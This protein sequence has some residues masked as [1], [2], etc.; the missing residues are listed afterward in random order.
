MGQPTTLQLSLLNQIQLRDL[1]DSLAEEY[2]DV[3]K[4]RLR[5]KGV[6]GVLEEIDIR[7]KSSAGF[8][9]VDTG[10]VAVVESREFQNAPGLKKEAKATRK[11]IMLNNG[12]RSE[13]A[14]PASGSQRLVQ[15]GPFTEIRNGKKITYIKHGDVRLEYQGERIT[16]IVGADGVEIPPGK[17]GD[18]KV[19]PNEHHA[20][21][22]I[23]Q[24]AERNN[25]RILALSP[26]RG[27]CPHCALRMQQYFIQQNINLDDA[28]P[29]SRQ[30]RTLWRSFLKDLRAAQRTATSIDYTLKNP[31]IDI[32]TLRTQF[33]SEMSKFRIPDRR[34][35]KVS[36][37]LKVA[38]PAMLA[39]DAA[40][41]YAKAAEELDKGN[42]E[43]AAK[44]LA[45]FGGRAAG[46]FVGAEACGLAFAGFG[47]V[48]P[49]L[50]T[51]VGALAGIL[52]GGA[53]GAYL[54]EKGAHELCEQIIAW[55][56][57]GPAPERPLPPSALSP[58][59]SHRLEVQKLQ[60]AMLSMGY[61]APETSIIGQLLD[62]PR[63]EGAL[64]QNA[65]QQIG[66][67]LVPLD[68]ATEVDSW[69]TQYPSSDQLDEGVSAEAIG[70]GAVPATS[71]AVPDGLKPEAEA[72]QPQPENSRP[73]SN[74]LAQP[75]PRP[76][77]QTETDQLDGANHED[78]LEATK[79]VHAEL[80]MPAK[81]V[82]D[83]PSTGDEPSIHREGGPVLLDDMLERVDNLQR[84]LA[85]YDNL[86]TGSAATGSREQFEADLTELRAIQEQ[87]VLSGSMPDTL[88][89]QARLNEVR[90]RYEQIDSDARWAE[91]R[92]SESLRR[93]QEDDR[94]RAEQADPEDS[95]RA[96]QTIE[97][98][99][100]RRSEDQ[101][102]QEVEERERR[103]RENERR[104]E[105]V[106]VE[107]RRRREQNEEDLDRENRNERDKEWQAEKARQLD[108]ARQRAYEERIADDLQRR[109]EVEARDH[110]ANIDADERRREELQQQSEADVRKLAD[111]QR[112]RANEAAR[113]LADEQRIQGEI[114]AQRRDD[115][116]RRARDLREAEIRTE[117]KQLA[118]REQLRRADDL[119]R[120]EQNR[121]REKQSPRDDQTMPFTQSPPQ[122][123][124]N[125]H[126]ATD[127]RLTDQED[128]RRAEDDRQIQEQRRADQ[129][130]A[131]EEHRVAEENRKQEQ[132]DGARP[133]APDRDSNR[134]TDGVADSQSSHIRQD[135]LSDEK[136]SRAAEQD[137]V[138]QRRVEEERARQQQEE[139]Q[140][141]RAEE[142]Q[143][144]QQEEL[145]QR[146]AE[147]ERAR[148]QQELQQRWAEEERARQQQELQ[149][150]WAEEER[151][152][153]QQEL[154]QR[155]AEEERARQQQEL[156]QRWAE[157]ERARQQQELQ[158]RWAE[159][160][161]A[162][163][164]EELQQRWAEEER[165]R[166]QEELQQRWAEEERARQQEEAERR[167][168]SEEEES[169]KH[170][171]GEILWPG[172]RPYP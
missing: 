75:N 60:Q 160:E 13:K 106:L 26:T 9:D 46:A 127:P 132:A 147:E 78:S 28:I 150:R 77:D 96:K 67:E 42:Q 138:Q 64:P 34:L 94:R 65:F 14:I 52:I 79:D 144:R 126:G 133:P 166:Q 56:K 113:Q 93:Q 19:F 101:Q 158:Q 18:V 81:T 80:L 47:S 112:F 61:S 84:R 23:L 124:G 157:E 3:L 15:Q 152:R 165:A 142:E 117:E 161:R 153:Q 167:R 63:L 118:D 89:T 83:E 37:Y 141:R 111:D 148:Q 168:L 109:R 72:V 103:A 95:K 97:S 143:A 48:I 105:Q 164:Q 49:G 134:S 43:A 162:R 11:V 2:R 30:T 58:P 57:G 8:F 99:M 54:G 7:R 102:L 59:R 62:S 27:C 156:Q 87:L 91:D 82:P 66:S 125:E 136:R 149:Q 128:R 6:L 50:G 172:D 39:F 85:N 4:I 140:Q 145:Q 40:T 139:L 25:Y 129:L 10:A 92:K 122:N 121:L 38:G 70:D 114:D 130:R 55:T 12:Y 51:T 159:E 20:E 115:N 146:W 163:Q 44:T 137:Q 151:A 1:V 86:I 116:E 171:S 90:S 71:P 33:K 76:P 155:W 31:H 32:A 74:I 24:W 123:E 98:A 108:D 88:A 22:R 170:V 104:D 169:R 45:E 154:Q 36:R 17:F 29:K 69:M 35:L 5:T 107:E 73:K 68:G 21:M 119:Y 100:G 16:R 135:E 41:S 120:E 53:V 131:D 110:A